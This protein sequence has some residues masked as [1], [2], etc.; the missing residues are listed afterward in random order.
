MIV[1]QKDTSLKARFTDDE[2]SY[3]EIDDLMHLTMLKNRD[4]W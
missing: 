2:G 1:L 4:D 3:W